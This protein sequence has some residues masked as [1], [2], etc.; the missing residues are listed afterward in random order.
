MVLDANS[1]TF[2]MY[3][4]VLNIIGINM[5][6]YLSRIAQIALLKTN[7][8]FT[9]IFAKYFDYIDVFSPKLAVELLKYTGINNYTIELEKD[10]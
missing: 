3:I 1:E 10:K 6:V 8:A 7:E 4:V 5:V 9:S 2:V